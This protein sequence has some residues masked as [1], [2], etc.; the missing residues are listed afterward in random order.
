MKTLRISD[1]VHRKMTATVGTLMAQTGKMQT[2]QDA[3]EATFQK[4]SREIFQRCFLIDDFITHEFGYVYLRKF[5]SEIFAD[6]S[7]WNRG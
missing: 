3:I 2:Y 4:L 7:I 5:F 1:D 6:F